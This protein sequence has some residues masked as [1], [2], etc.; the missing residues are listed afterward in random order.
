MQFV[1]PLQFAE[2]L[3]VSN[4]EGLLLR[5]VVDLIGDLHVLPVEVLAPLLP[6]PE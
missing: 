4:A 6:Q 3:P 2:R 1:A 5:V